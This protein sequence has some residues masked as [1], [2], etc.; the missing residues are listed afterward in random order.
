LQNDIL[1]YKFISFAMKGETMKS[2]TISFIYTILLLLLISSNAFAA[3]Y[4][5]KPDGNDNFDGKS[6]AQAWKT[7]KKVSDSVSGKGDDVYF[8]CDGTWS[9]GL[10]WV[11]WSGT[12]D[13]RATIGSYYGNGTIGVSGRKP[14][15]NGN[16]T[17]PSDNYLG[18]V[19]VNQQDYVTVENLN[20]INSAG[21]GLYFKNSSYSIARNVDVSNCERSCI[22]WTGT[23]DSNGLA[24]NCTATLGG[25]GSHE[26]RLK[27]WPFCIGSTGFKYLT[28]RGCKIYETYT[29]GIGF[30]QRADNCIAENNLIYDAQKA[31]IY[32]DLTQGCIVRNNM[33]YGT[34][35][36]NFHKQGDTPGPGLYVAD[37]EW[38]TP[39]SSN[40]VWYGNL[41][42]N[43]FAGMMIGVGMDGAQFANSYVYNNT[44]VGCTYGVKIY[45][46]SFS[47]SAI[48]NNIIWLAGGTSLYSGSSTTNGL[49]WNYNN[50]SASVSDDQSGSNDVIGEPSL[51]KTDGWRSLNRDSLS[52]TDFLLIGDST[53]KIAGQ[54]I[55][56][57]YN[58]FLDLTKNTWPLSIK[59]LD[60]SE[61]TSTWA[62]G[63]DVAS[64]HTGTILI[65]PTNL[66]IH[67]SQ[68]L[69]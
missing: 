10:L 54:K 63:A 21:T 41:V 61:K 17:K 29:E 51:R 11:D 58:T 25:I 19:H 53:L 6:D 12:S 37:E 28:V 40:N 39:R 64:E 36:S 57:E 34:G 1:C 62:I 55:G 45:G 9:T 23:N 67:V 7:L 15:I 14:I 68:P 43:Y 13:D 46:S 24:E 52:T 38:D 50:W 5:V 49:T 69:S 22:A 20:I 3:T 48:K 16:G 60:Q 31:G 44:F 30:Y 35:N 4:Y 59:I 56:S 65:A 26:G 33:I 8:K 47:N 18:L 27:D 32:I 66:K 42:A 2:H